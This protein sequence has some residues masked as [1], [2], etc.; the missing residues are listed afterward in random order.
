MQKLSIYIND[1]KIQ[2]QMRMAIVKEAKITGTNSGDILA[3][4]IVQK[5]KRDEKIIKIQ[6]KKKM[7]KNFSTEEKLSKEV[8]L[9]IPSGV[10]KKLSEITKIY[11]MPIELYILKL[12]RD[13]VDGRNLTFCGGIR[14]ILK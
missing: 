12:L 14:R 9:K 4:A 3:S 5:L 7:S 2:K 1:V 10:H 11:N 13:E 8:I 6:C